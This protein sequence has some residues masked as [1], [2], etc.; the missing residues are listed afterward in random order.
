MA[1]SLDEFDKEINTK[2]TPNLKTPS[3]LFQGDGTWV[4][5]EGFNSF[6]GKV[7]CAKNPKF[8]ICVLVLVAAKKSDFKHCVTFNFLPGAPQP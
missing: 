5:A 7:S 6:L 8:C 3:L 4:L 2:L 1:S